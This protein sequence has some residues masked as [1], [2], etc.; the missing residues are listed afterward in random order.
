MAR[1]DYADV[2]EPENAHAWIRAAL[3][4][5]EEENEDPDE[6]LGGLTQ[7]IH[8]TRANPKIVPAKSLYVAFVQIN[9]EV[10]AK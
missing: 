5:C 4:L 3:D 2:T 8:A 9:A 7:T 1:A 10:L 6:R